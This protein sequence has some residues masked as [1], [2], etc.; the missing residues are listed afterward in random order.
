M[1]IKKIKVVAAL[2]PDSVLRKMMEMYEKGGKGFTDHCHLRTVRKIQQRGSESSDKIWLYGFSGSGVY[3]SVL[4]DKH[5]KV[6]EGSFYTPHGDSF[7]GRNGFVVG[8]EKLDHL[9]TITVEDWID[10]YGGGR[11][12]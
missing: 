8:D 10:Q 5:D 4:T 1:T 3:H 7:Q 11:A 9:K 2:N 12:T 6:L